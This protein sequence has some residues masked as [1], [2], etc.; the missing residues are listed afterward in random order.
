MITPLFLYGSPISGGLTSPHSIMPS[1]LACMSYNY[2]VFILNLS[3]HNWCPFLEQFCYVSL[4][5]L[6]LY[7][8]TRKQFLYGRKIHLLIKKISVVMLQWFKIIEHQKKIV[9]AL[10]LNSGRSSI[11]I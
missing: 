8:K 3:L 11:M 7:L 2:V 1:S 9:F 5:N 6:H 10:V 4:I